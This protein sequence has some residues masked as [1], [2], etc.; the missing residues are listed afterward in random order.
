MAQFITKISTTVMGLC[1]SGCWE[2]VTRINSGSS[3]SGTFQKDVT[4]FEAMVAF[5]YGA[6]TVTVSACSASRNLY[7][8]TATNKTPG[9]NGIAIISAIPAGC[10]DWSVSASGGHV[11]VRSVDVIYPQPPTINGVLNCSSWGTNAWCTGTENLDLTAYEP[12]G[13]SVIISGD[14]N[15]TSLY[16]PSGAYL[17]QISLGRHRDSEL[18]GNIHQ[19][20]R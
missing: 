17:L 14:L 1:G 9:F 3:I 15:G 4:Y 10:R 20:V 18:F 19:W 16:L 2:N 11:H 5:E 13:E 7:M 12:Q 6:G 8:G